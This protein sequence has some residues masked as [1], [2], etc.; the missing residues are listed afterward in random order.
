MRRRKQL[1]STTDTHTTA[2]QRYL[3]EAWDALE[4]MPPTCSGAIMVASRALG[5]AERAIANLQSIEDR[6]ER[7]DRDE[8]FASASR[9]VNAA[10]GTIQF[11]A[12]T[13]DAPHRKA[14]ERPLFSRARGKAKR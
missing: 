3:N 6:K 10:W 11:L 4:Q 8:L 12:Y 5:N 13:C 2:A 7:E 9:A 14:S 1:G